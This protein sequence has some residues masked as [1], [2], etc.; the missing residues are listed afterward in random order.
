MQIDQI[1]VSQRSLKRAGQIPA[2]IETLKNGWLPPIT[3][4]EGTDGEIQVEDGHHRLVA[5]YLSGRTHLEKEEYILVQKD[6]WRPRCEKFTEAIRSWRGARLESVWAL[7]ALWDRHPPLPLGG[8]R[9]GGPNTGSTG[10]DENVAAQL[11][12]FYN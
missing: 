12:N 3:L 4:I 10:Q 5:I 11:G 9:K 1:W 6:Q 7:N 2:M 8:A